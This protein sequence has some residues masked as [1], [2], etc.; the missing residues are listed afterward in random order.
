MRTEINEIRQNQGANKDK[1]LL[2]ELSD[3]NNKI[4]MLEKEL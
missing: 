1:E 2:R 3:A 4:H